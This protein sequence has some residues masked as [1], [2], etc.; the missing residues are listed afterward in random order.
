MHLGKVVAVR[1]RDCKEGVVRSTKSINLLMRVADKD[2]SSVRELPDEEVSHA[3]GAILRLVQ[4][5][6]VITEDL[7]LRKLPLL[8]VTF[9]ITD[10]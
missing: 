1:G 5:Y 2:E 10:I 8:E 4:Q 3:L 9:K 7:R 6:D